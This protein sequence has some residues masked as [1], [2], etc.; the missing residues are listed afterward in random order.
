MADSQILDSV[1]ATTALP[2]PTAQGK[3]FS[4]PLPRQRALLL[5][6]DHLH[7]YRP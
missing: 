1:D 2:P 5:F 7:P 6:H 4:P 3:R